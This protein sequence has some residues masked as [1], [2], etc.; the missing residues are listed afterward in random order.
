MSRIASDPENAG[1]R[2]GPEL[3]AFLS[4]MLVAVL[5]AFVF[6]TLSPSRGWETL[7]SRAWGS[8]QVQIGITLVPVLIATAA[9]PWG[10]VALSRI[11][12]SCAAGT[13]WFSI[14]VL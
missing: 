8:L 5:S 9:L 14:L 12:I 7:M 4:G 1:L 6:D 10:R 3:I 13:L 2:Y 11:L